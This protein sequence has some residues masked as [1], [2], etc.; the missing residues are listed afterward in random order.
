MQTETS[1]DPLTV[2]ARFA[3]FPVAASFWSSRRPASQASFFV[4]LCASHEA[5]SA[6][7]S[8]SHAVF[9]GVP[10]RS[11]SSLRPAFRTSQPYLA[12]AFSR[13]QAGSSKHAPSAQT[14]Q[15]RTGVQSS[16]WSQTF[17]V[18]HSRFG[19]QSIFGTQSKLLSSGI[20]IFL[21]KVWSANEALVVRQGCACSS[22][23]LTS[24]ATSCLLTAIQLE[25]GFGKIQ[26]LHQFP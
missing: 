10:R 8:F 22:A 13:A 14:W 20:S 2:P 26:A 25:S 3:K 17:A 4:D 23:A 18:V 6:A 19:V 15:S 16:A 24:L 21:L 9:A 12:A 11:H 5:C 7:L 1:A